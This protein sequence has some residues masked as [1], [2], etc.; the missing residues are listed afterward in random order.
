MLNKRGTS[1]DPLGTPPTQ[2]KLNYEQHELFI[3]LLCFYLK[4]RYEVILKKAN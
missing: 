3:L 4:N 2:K 1:I